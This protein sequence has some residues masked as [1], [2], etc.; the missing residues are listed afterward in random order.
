ME[1]RAMA[2]R[3][4]QLRM[5]FLEQV[6]L[7]LSA[8][9]EKPRVLDAAVH[10]AADLFNASAGSILVKDKNGRRARFAAAIGKKSHALRRMS[11]SLDRGVVGWCIRNGRMA[12]VPDVSKDKRYDP[13]V[14]EKIGFTT[15][16][17]LCGPL[18]KGKTVLGALELV[19]I[20][21][22]KGPTKQ[23]RER[24]RAVCDALGRILDP[25]K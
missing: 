14:S 17:I 13:A 9:K 24:F 2:G 3:T 25:E 18:K 16:N 20:R 1:E 23:E 4:E 8:G 15:K 10:A 6:L 22:G 12:W 11:M 5:R 7:D 21:G 19:N